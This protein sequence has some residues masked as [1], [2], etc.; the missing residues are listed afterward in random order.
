MPFRPM[1]SLRQPHLPCL[2]AVLVFTTLMLT[3]TASATS[4][5]RL[6]ED[7]D[8]DGVVDLALAPDG[9][10]SPHGRSTAMRVVFGSPRLSQP[11]TIFEQVRTPE[12]RLRV[13]AMLRDEP[14]SRAADQHQRQERTAD[15]LQ[16][17]RS[18]LPRPALLETFS[19]SLVPAMELEVDLHGL[20][21]LM[22]HPEVTSIEPVGYLSLLTAQGTATIFM[23]PWRSTNGGRGTTIAIVDDGID[24][25]HPQLGGGGFPNS[26]VWSG[27]DFA[28]ATAG[29]PFDAD[30]RPG[31]ANFHGTACAGIAAGS[32]T[33]TAGDFTGGAAP[34]ALL[35]A[36]KVTPDNSSV[37]TTT[38]LGAAWEWALINRLARPSAPI[39][40]ISNSLGFG[41]HTDAA[42][43]DGLFPLL[44]EM[45]NQ[46]D[47]AGVVLV[48]ATGNNGY[49]NAVAYPSCMSAVVAVGSVS[50]GSNGVF[51]TCV[52]FDSCVAP[53]PNPFSTCPPV[54][55]VTRKVARYT[56][57]TSTVV[58]Y[59]NSHAMLDWLAPADIAT[60]TDVVGAGGHNAGNYHPGFAGTSASTPYAAGAVATI[61]SLAR[62][63]I[64]RFLTA[65]EVITLITQTGISIVDS[66]NGLA[67]PRVNTA[68]AIARLPFAPTML[69]VNPGDA[70]SQLSLEWQAHP[71]ATGYRITYHADGQSPPDTITVGAVTSAL[72]S[73]L[74][75]STRYQLS[76]TTIN[77]YGEGPPSVPISYTTPPASPAPPTALFAQ[78]GANHGSV[79]VT[80]NALPGLTYRIYVINNRE[81]VI[82][83][84]ATSSHVVD[85]LPVGAAVGFQIT[86]TN[87]A[88]ESERSAIVYSW[89][90]SGGTS[91]DRFEPNDS[92]AA[93]TPINVAPG[94]TEI[95]GLESRGNDDWYRLNIG[96][97]THLRVDLDFPH[98]QGNLQMQLW[99]VRPQSING[100]GFV[101]AESYSNDDGERLSYVNTTNPQSMYLRVYGEAGATHPQYR[102]LLEGVE[103]DDFF[104]RGDLFNGNPCLLAPAHTIQPHTR[105][106]NLISRDED[107]YRLNVA[108]LESVTISVDYEFFS[109]NLLLL[110]LED[111]PGDCA[112]PYAYMLGGSFIQ[113]PTPGQRMLNFAVNGRSS[114][115]VRVAGSNR[116]TNFYELGF[117]DDAR[118]SSAPRLING[119]DGTELSRGTPTQL[120][121]DTATA[122]RSTDPF[123]PNDT[124]QT[125]ALLNLP[126]TFNTFTNLQLSGED[127]YR[128]SLPPDT[129]IRVEM[130]H[131]SGFGNMQ[132]QMWDRRSTLP[133]SF[134]TN[135]GESYSSTDTEIITYVNRTNP[136]ELFLRIYP[137]GT[138]N[139]APYS[140]SLE[141]FNLDDPL[142]FN[143]KVDNNSPCNP[144]AVLSAGAVHQNLICRDDD[145]YRID[146]SEL[147]TLTVQVE[148]QFFSG[149]L[150]LMITADDP[151][152]CNGAFGQI[153]AGAFSNEPVNIEQISN[154]DVSGRNSVLLRV[155]GAI[156][157]TNFYNLTIS[158]NPR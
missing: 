97:F 3:S 103:A 57:S 34:E 128:F 20:E 132:M 63:T 82:N 35:V 89:A 87:A 80:W 40:V 66:R 127:W 75:P 116:Q 6:I 146:T 111:V 136:S 29:A 144:L 105:I 68:A 153:L 49:C 134:G 17:F 76:V 44:T 140:L 64:G 47:D 92:P 113:D 135:V 139:T 43:C 45:A 1:P 32:R 94:R 73:G 52:D 54:N 15:R 110:L 84:G 141:L 48:A 107:W 26:K 70:P 24:Y 5:T 104:D 149:N 50:D 31:F 39:V 10:S 96:E 55:G 123:E 120:R 99:D 27:A 18:A 148:H 101:A 152:N 98:A 67:R 131:Q 138:P 41:K 154:L 129:H 51:E 157:E 74:S 81:S 21:F 79:L 69:S 121:S 125:A 90:R 22:D 112:N 61:Q 28:G 109:G 14:Y 95:S 114:L 86:A 142:E 56:S 118:A 4:Y 30:P 108:G 150:H 155:Y 147:S 8:G 60:T 78:P 36:L 85:G 58:P 46:L 71:F 100:W 59:T 124:Y 37:L 126:A 2:I 91:D 42:T 12:A 156:R 13:V 130:N 137:E 62:E 33:N 133:L 122:P 77:Q 11:R 106:T 143:Q 16:S 23:E 102:L 88:G 151:Q 117:L 19:F 119:A 72:I 65:P 158:G 83:A 145:W 115:L 7:L 25:T 38:G 9:E 53:P 93:A